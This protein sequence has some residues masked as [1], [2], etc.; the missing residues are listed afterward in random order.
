MGRQIGML[1]IIS[2]GILQKPDVHVGTTSRWR[3]SFF[4]TG[5]MQSVRVRLIRRLPR[6][7]PLASSRVHQENLYPPNEGFAISF[8][9]FFVRTGNQT[10]VT[11][12]AKGWSFELNTL[13][14]S[15]SKLKLEFPANICN[16]KSRISADYDYERGRGR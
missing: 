4:R 9:S 5:R 10:F 3:S 13:E 14:N 1:Q 12:V 16:K 7:I 6:R 11:N 15:S 8:C 2:V